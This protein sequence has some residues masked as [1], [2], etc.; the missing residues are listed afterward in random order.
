MDCTTA[1]AT[2]DAWLGQCVADIGR[3]RFHARLLEGIH[4]VLG[5]DHFSHLSYDPEGRIRHAAA[6]SVCNQPLI[7]STTDIYVKHL[8]RR[9]PNYPLVRDG[10]TRPQAPARSGADLR[11]LGMSPTGIGDAEYRRVLFDEP[12]FTGKVSLL[13]LQGGHRCYLN[14]YFSRVPL[15]MGHAATLLGQYGSTLMGLACR[16]DELAF[17]QEEEK[18]VE[19]DPWSALSPRERSTAEWLMDGCTAKEIGR[20]MALSPATIVTYKERI[21]SKLGVGS[22]REFLAL[23]RPPERR[24]ASLGLRQLS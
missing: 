21:F 10:S 1:L 3:P 20:K 14:F 7:D 23:G 18:E 4:A 5:A 12:G 11:L 9:D 19:C 22:L 8:Y 17:P 13:G 16:H 6:A 24:P 15:D 2:R